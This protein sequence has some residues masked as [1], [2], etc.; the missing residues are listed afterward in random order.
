[1]ANEIKIFKVCMAVTVKI[2]VFLDVMLSNLLSQVAFP[3][4]MEAVNS[5]ETVIHLYQ[6]TWYHIPEY[7]SLQ[8]MN[9]S[10]S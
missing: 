5:S 7:S 10:L 8:Y 6:I 4:K 1:M 2:A 9:V 3:L